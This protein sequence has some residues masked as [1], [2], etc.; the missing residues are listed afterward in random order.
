MKPELAKTTRGMH[1]AAGKRKNSHARRRTPV[2]SM[3][4]KGVYSVPLAA[5]LLRLDAPK[6]RVNPAA[7]RRWAFGYKRRGIAYSPAVDASDFRTL[8]SLSFLEVVELLHVAAFLQAG[9]SWRKVRNAIGVARR[10]LRQVSQSERHPLARHEWFADGSNLYMRLASEIRGRDDSRAVMEAVGDAQVVID[11]CLQVYLKQID[12]DPVTRLAQRWFP[13]GVIG[14]P[15][16]CDPLRELGLP[17]TFEGG[18]RT[19]LLARHARAGDAVQFLAG[20]YRVREHAVAA[21]VAF[22]R[23]LLAHRAAA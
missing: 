23:S 12:F 16:V 7:I 14:G 8:D 1:I 4:G 3:I 6:A 15:I 19:D 2:L 11:K 9:A 13:G 22:E 21:A 17:V 5:N 10:H 20:S 18:V